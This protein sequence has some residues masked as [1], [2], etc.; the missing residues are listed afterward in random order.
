[1]QS[2]KRDLLRKQNMHVKLQIRIQFLHF[3]RLLYFHFPHLLEIT[4]ANVESSIYVPMA[5]CPQLDLAP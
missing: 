3:K 1:M 2:I 4:F 5:V